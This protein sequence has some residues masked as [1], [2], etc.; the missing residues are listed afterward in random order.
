MNNLQKLQVLTEELEIQENDFI[1]YV[2]KA[3]YAILLVSESGEVKWCNEFFHNLFGYNKQDII[4]K[5]LKPVLRIS[6]NTSNYKKLELETK[7]NAATEFILKKS[8]LIRKNK[9][10]HKKITLIPYE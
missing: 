6:L 7:N 4:D 10:I 8:E 9:L 5:V 3:E 2:L 1:D